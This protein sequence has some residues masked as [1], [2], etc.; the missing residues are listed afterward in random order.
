MKNKTMLE[1]AAILFIAMAV[2]KIVGALLKIPLGNILGGLGMSYFSSAYSVFGPVFALTA[3]AIPTV[4]TKIVA[5]NAAAGKFKN[6]RKIRKVALRA[7]ALL[8]FGGTV[9][10]LVI[11]VPFTRFVAD[12]PKS[13]PSM[14]IIAPSVFFCCIASVYRGYYEGLRNTLPTAISQ[15]I[16][17]VIKSAL[18]VTLSFFVLRATSSLSYAAAAAVLGITI[19]EVFGLLFL[20]LRGFASDGIS[21]EELDFSP[22]PESGMRLLGKFFKEAFPITLGALAVNL[23]SLIDLLTITN[24][25]NY[26]INLNRSFFLARFTYGLQGGIALEDLGNFI[27]G[28]YTGIVASIFTLIP[29]MTGMLSKSAL[30]AVTAAWERGNIDGLRRSLKILFKSTFVVGLP[31]CL[32]MA[33]FSEPVLNLL[34]S[35]KPAEAYVC[36]RPLLILSLGGITLSL[37]ATLFAVFFAIGRSDLPVKLMLTGAIVK[38]CMNLWLLRIPHLNING[39]AIATIGC[40]AVICILG[41][42]CLARLVKIKLGLP[43]F[44]AKAL[45]N[46][47]L[48]AGSALLAF[49]FVFINNGKIIQL[50]LSI[51][52]GA[53]VYGIATLITDRSTFMNYAKRFIKNKAQSSLQ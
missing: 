29:A 48:C 23:N 5:Q 44:F 22:E 53:F 45:L 46:S 21:K 31:L 19:S 17:A 6:V 40:Y 11:T 38:L 10:I 24:C 3:A 25:I 43:V 52:T 41:F 15:V 27:Y 47:A 1:N 20:I 4:L 39:A 7:A 36:A 42:I 12:A 9:L 28:S 51:A 8:G 2:T 16:E 32:G 30:P 26:A 35:T 13:I 49:N 33:A 50:V 14:L 34:Y 18:G 37:T